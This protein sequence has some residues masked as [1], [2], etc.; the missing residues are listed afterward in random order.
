PTLRRA[1]IVSR[2]L[3]AFVAAGRTRRR[4]LLSGQD[5]DR[6]PQAHHLRRLGPVSLIDLIITLVGAR[7]DKHGL[8]LQG[9]DQHKKIAWIVTGIFFVLGLIIGG[10]AANSAPAPQSDDSSIVSEA[11]EAADEAPVAEPEEEPADEPA[12]AEPA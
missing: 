6:R 3:A 8:P 10:V 9:Y 12:E 1:E 2:H 11:E 4:S 7:K 5:R